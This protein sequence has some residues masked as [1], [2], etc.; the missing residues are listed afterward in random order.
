MNKRILTLMLF[1][2]LSI[3][4]MSCSDQKTYNDLFTVAYYSGTGRVAVETSYVDS[5]LDVESGSKLD[6]PDDPYGEGVAFLGWYK[7]VERTEP[8]DFDNDVV[9]QSIVLYAKWDIL[10]LSV[11]YVF[12]AAGGQLTDEPIT[13][14]TVLE[15][16]VL[17]KAQREGSLF[18]GWILTPVEDY[19]VGDPFVSATTGYT[20]DLTLYALFENK[21]YTVRFRS[22]MDG[23][24]NPSTHV[25]E[26]A[27]EIE[28]P[29]LQDT[30]TKHFVGWFG[31]D[32]SE[33]GDWGFQYTNGNLY[34]GKAN[35]DEATG[36]W[37]FIPQGVTVYAKWEDK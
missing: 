13:E 17:P 35:F 16:K 15:N 32:G 11:D 36:E 23:V 26:Y 28:W 8:W 25:I 5:V 37:S 6:Q 21:E 19:V 29:V 20:Q 3:G 27:S 4:L 2:F 22:L 31:L 14:F 30:A 1:V 7:D 10:T 33:T 12:D 18:L 9:T 34:L 24:A